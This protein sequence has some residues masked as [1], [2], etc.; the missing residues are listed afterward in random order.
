M[1]ENRPGMKLEVQCEWCRG[2]GGDINISFS[3]NGRL[4]E[5]AIIPQTVMATLISFFYCGDLCIR[6]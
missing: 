1:L 6:N 4:S 2:V 3:L 5:D